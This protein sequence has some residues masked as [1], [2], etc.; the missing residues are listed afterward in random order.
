MPRWEAKHRNQELE[1]ARL[2]AHRSQRARMGSPEY[3]EMIGGYFDDHPWHQKVRV[4][5]EDRDFPATKHFP[6][7]LE[8]TDEIYQF[9]RLFA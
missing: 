1:R 8:V 5:V 2:C 6:P 7:T 4:N 9:K 3:G